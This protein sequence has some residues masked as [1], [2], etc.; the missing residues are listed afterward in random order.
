V[1]R[2]VIPS[3]VMAIMAATSFVGPTTTSAQTCTFQ[4]GFAT[5]RDM[6]VAQSG[7]IIGACIEN[8]HHNPFNGDAL[9]QT[10]GG[11]MVWRKADNWTA[12]TNGA[13]TWLNGPFGLA[14]RPNAGPLFPWENPAPVPQPEPTFA[15]P[16][17]TATPVPAGPTSTPV[18]NDAKPTVTLK[19]DDTSV[20]QGDTINI[21][22]IG[23]DDKGLNTVVWYAS[24][25]GDNALKDTHTLDCAGANPCRQSW[26]VTTDDTGTITIHAYAI[27]SAGQKS[28]EVTEDIKIKK[29]SATPTPAPTPT[30]HH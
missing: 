11:L 21:T 22:V 5:L 8:E 23:S 18:P 6:I 29:A 24:D 12:F 15:V 4:L 26:A 2:R 28:D 19:I 10:T 25:T 13:T 16:P 20:D 3:A 30:V 1:W 14:V 27:D 17:P 9:Q 7:D